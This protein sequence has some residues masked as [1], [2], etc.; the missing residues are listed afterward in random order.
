MIVGDNDIN[1]TLVLDD[2]K[3]SIA[4]DFLIQYCLRYQGK[5]IKSISLGKYAENDKFDSF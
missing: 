2:N 1:I 3:Y 5:K 4:N